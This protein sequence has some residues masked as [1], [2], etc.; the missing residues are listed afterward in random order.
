MTPLSKMGSPG[1]IP[2]EY[3]HLSITPA[4]SKVFA[5]LLAKCLN[6]YDGIDYLFPVYSLAFV[7]VW[8]LVMPS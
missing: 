8:T 4:L 1:L 7:K 5:Y 6:A 3:H 2:S